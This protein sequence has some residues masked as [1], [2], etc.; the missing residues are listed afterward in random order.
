MLPSSTALWRHVS[1]RAKRLTM[2]GTYLPRLGTAIPGPRSR[3]RV[4]VLARHEC[5]AVTARR[6]RRADQLGA[7]DDD[8]IV[9]REAVGAN[10]IDVDDN[11]FVDLTSG[12]GVA[13]VGHRH[14]AVVAAAT[15]Q[16]ERLVHAMGD[17][18]PDATRIALLERLA[19]IAPIGLEV[20]ML[21]LSGSD[22][23]DAATKTALL[24]TGRPGV[25]AFERGYHGLALGVL[26]LQA[27]KP[28]FTAPFRAVTHGHVR[29]LPFGCDLDDLEAALDDSIGLVLVEP[30]QGRGG[31]WE[32][33]D[34][35]LAGLTERARARG[36]LVAFDEVQSGMG[37]TGRWFVA[38]EV[39]P[40][41]LCVGKALGGGY[42]ISA[43][44]GTR[45]VMDAWGAS[46]GEALHTQTFLGHPVGC[47][48]ALAVLDVLEGGM[49]DAV[50][51]RGAFL[52]DVLIRRG[53]PVRGRGLMLAATV[54]GDALVVARLLLQRGWL[55]LPA[56]PDSVSLTPPA[57]LTDAQ[58]EGFVAALAEVTE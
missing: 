22:A 42:P 40:D 6:A 21:G 50:V 55:V 19:G 7:S 37:R 51:S 54:P 29:H 15:T 31:I 13:L 11:I 41:L 18:W 33:P 8:P 34:G 43:C 17:A 20:S 3:Q 23:I 14:P 56:G 4:D 45:A 30:I 27:Y 58:I 36:A 46:Q 53:F 52:R 39:V 16:A 2:M 57:T 32:A 10:V 28:S 49:L 26:G 24:A 25:L 1:R 38:E 35:W 5:P 9:W 48:A 47:A 44:L 12:F